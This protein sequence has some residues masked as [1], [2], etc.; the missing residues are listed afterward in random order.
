MDFALSPNQ[1]KTDNFASTS[2]YNITKII[3][4]SWVL[5]KIK[6]IL[7]IVNGKNSLGNQNPK[8]VCIPFLIAI[9]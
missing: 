5:G 1:S 6:N 8:M 2:K 4:H 9:V 3:K 7:S